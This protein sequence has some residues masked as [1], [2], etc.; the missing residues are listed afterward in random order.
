[1][2]CCLAA[3]VPSPINPPQDDNFDTDK[4]RGF[5]GNAVTGVL[6]GVFTSID[7]ALGNRL[8]L[9]PRAVAAIADTADIAAAAAAAVNP[10]SRMTTLTR[11]RL[12]ASSAMQSQAFCQAYSLPLML[13][14]ATGC[15]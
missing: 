15:L 6:P 1:L 14:W 7:A 5:I 13:R 9:T 12:E 8:P 2:L 10:T 11:T 3:Y 4:T